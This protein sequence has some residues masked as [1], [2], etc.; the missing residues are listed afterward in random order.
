MMT[1]RR[2]I[3]TYRLRKLKNNAVTR[4]QRFIDL[5]RSKLYKLMYYESSENLSM[6][7]EFA[8]VRTKDKELLYGFIRH[9]LFLPKYR[10]GLL[11]SEDGVW[12]DFPPQC[13]EC[14]DPV[15]EDK[16]QCILEDECY[17]SYIA[18]FNFYQIPDNSKDRELKIL[19]GE[20]MFWDLT[21]LS[22]S[23]IRLLRE[24]P[25]NWKKAD[26]KCRA[27]DWN[28]LMATTIRVLDTMTKTKEVPEHEEP[29]EFT[30]FAPVKSD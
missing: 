26:E 27:A 19:S 16:D 11:E 20:T 9:V 25:S 21:L 6:A 15:F 30:G 18:G 12:S 28:P 22:K 7:E 29:D 4:I 8:R 13:D 3:L 14:M 24:D 5:R 10:E 23:E 1:P 2:I 17:V